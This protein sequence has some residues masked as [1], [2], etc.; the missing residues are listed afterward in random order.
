MKRTALTR[1]AFGEAKRATYI[2]E[3]KFQTLVE[4]LAAYCGW[5]TF[6][7]N[8]PQR[9]PAGFPDLV[10]FRDRIIFAELKVRR[11]SDGRMGKLAPAQ[12]EYAHTIQR[13]QGEY[14]SWLFP[15]DKDEIARVLA[16][17]GQTVEWTS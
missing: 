17:P 2:A 11:P 3:S 10:M 15:D 13:A 1:T 12:I 6:H 4:E 14:Y 9:S 8:A 16:K 7:L 5:T